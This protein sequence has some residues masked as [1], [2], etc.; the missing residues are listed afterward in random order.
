MS[1][2]V[3]GEIMAEVVSSQLKHGRNA[4]ISFDFNGG[5][6]LA[7]L[8]EEF[9]EVCTEL[10]YDGRSKDGPVVSGLFHELKQLAAMAGSW[11]Q[12][13]LDENPDL[14]ATLDPNNAFP[15]M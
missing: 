1:P 2:Q 11:M 7:V 3:I 9:G 6:R 10:T 4:M 8:G 15:P 13:I 14:R 12:V 5:N